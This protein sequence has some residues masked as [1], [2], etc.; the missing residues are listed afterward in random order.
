M[1]ASGESSLAGRPLS[2]RWRSTVPLRV[3]ITT[4]LRVRA[5]HWGA[6]SGPA[7]P[8]APAQDGLALHPKSA[9]QNAQLINYE[10]YD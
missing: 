3:S 2:W 8:A 4:S 10:P 9:R 5:G 7:L 6:S 1:P